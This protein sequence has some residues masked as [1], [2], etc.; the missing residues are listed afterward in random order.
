MTLIVWGVFYLISNIALV[1]GECFIRNCD[2][3]SCNEFRCKSCL[4][5]H[6]LISGLCPSCPD[7]CTTCDGA[8]SCTE[9]TKGYWGDWC[10]RRCSA[11]CSNGCSITTGICNTYVTIVAIAGGSGSVVLIIIIIIVVILYIRWKR[12]K[13]KMIHQTVPVQL[14]P[15]MPVATPAV[16]QY[17]S[18]SPYLNPVPQPQCTSHIVGQ[19]AYPLSYSH[20]VNPVF[21]SYVPPV[22]VQPKAKNSLQ[23]TLKTVETAA[24]VGNALGKLLTLDQ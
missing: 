14:S 21:S 10:Q 24:R 13:D 3:D 16:V 15:G 6:Y 19:Q 23:S 12:N 4:S 5:G 7:D 2:P 20:H 11:G 17:N 8:L 1:G 22:H 9:C 18:A